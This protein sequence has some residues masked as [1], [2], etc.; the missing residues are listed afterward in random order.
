MAEPSETTPRANEST[1]SEAP[2]NAILSEST[3]TSSNATPNEATSSEAATATETT[4]KSE[5]PT[6][7]INLKVKASDGT[8]IFFKIKKNTPLRKL[9]ETYCNRQGTEM[10]TARFM[11]D[12]QRLKPESTPNEVSTSNNQTTR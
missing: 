9:M 10:S 1:S 8:E 7:H 12:G 2:S 4:P 5:I 6:E 11:F 3:A